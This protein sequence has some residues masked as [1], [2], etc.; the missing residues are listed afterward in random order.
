MIDDDKRTVLP[1]IGLLKD[2]VPPNQ[3]LIADFGE[4]TTRK[5]EPE[6]HSMNPYDLLKEKDQEIKLLKER[7]MKL[8]KKAS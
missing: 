3:S 5:E 7:L 2:L 4:C 1:E 8:E 6:K